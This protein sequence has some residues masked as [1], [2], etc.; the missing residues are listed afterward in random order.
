MCEEKR[1][2]VQTRTSD[3]LIGNIIES[4]EESADEFVEPRRKPNRTRTVE[5]ASS[6][7]AAKAFD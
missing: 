3:G 2:R 6:T 7:T 4:V 5:A 1:T